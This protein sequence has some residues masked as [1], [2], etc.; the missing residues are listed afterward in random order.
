MLLL[1]RLSRFCGVL[2]MDVLAGGR[3]GLVDLM[4][5]VGVL[6]ALDN[7]EGA[8]VGVVLYCAC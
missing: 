5:L 4:G 1:V 3:V 6:I 8:M 2:E 7:L